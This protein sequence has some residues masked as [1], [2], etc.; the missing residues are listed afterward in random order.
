MTG[1]IEE[2]TPTRLDGIKIRYHGDY[3]LGQVLLR[4]N[5]FVIID[6]EG[7]PARTLDER[8]QKHSPLRDVAGMLRSFNYAGYTALS[9][10]V[11]ERPEDYAMVEL[12]TREW[13]TE[14]ARTFLQ[15]YEENVRGSGLYADW[16]G[17][18][19]LLDLF[20]LEKALYELRYELNNRPAWVHI[21]LHGILEL[22][23]EAA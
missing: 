11:A 20:V 7:E 19:R 2:R 14:T 4:Q 21:P 1:Y 16:E 6:F 10:M 8:R 9:R 13:E 17:A 15:A 5:D 12:W 23:G 18:R 3:H 22:V